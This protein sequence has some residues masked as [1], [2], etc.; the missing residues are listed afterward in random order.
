MKVVILAGGRGSRLAEETSV[1]PKPLV[2][3]GEKPILWH[4]M[5]IYAHFGCKDF[6]VCAGYKGYQI[7]EYFANLVLHHSDITVDLAQH[8]I[9]YHQCSKPDWRVSIVD[10][11][12]D[13]MTG[14]RL[15]RVRDYLDPGETFCLTYGD[16]VGN[17]DIAAEIAFHRRHGLLATM[18]T[19]AP[20]GR[21]GMVNLEGERVSAFVEKP[22]AGNQR[23][24]AG[25]FVLQPE[26]LDLI[27]GDDTTWENTPLEAL[28]ARG[29]LAAYSH[30][31]FWRP[32]DTLRER[33]HLDEMWASGQAPWKVWP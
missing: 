24:N 29:Q 18:C 9:H 5:S 32:M 20:P 4:I 15:K 28:V 14:G 19:V 22:S 26:V 31:G 8:K 1:R 33:I 3:I 27:E 25:F 10:T 12:L 7:K 30:D 23:V 2:E 17:V 11:G 16:G 21:F 13:T 6:I